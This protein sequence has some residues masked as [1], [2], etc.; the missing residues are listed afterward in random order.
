MPSSDRNISGVFPAALVGEE[1]IRDF[2]REH[3]KPLKDEEEALAKPWRSGFRAQLPFFSLLDDRQQAH[4]RGIFSHMLPSPEVEVEDFDREERILL[5]VLSETYIA[6][7]RVFAELMSEHD[8]Q[9]L[10]VVKRDMPG[11]VIA[12][13]LS[14]SVFVFD[15]PDARQIR[16]YRYQNIYGNR[17]V[18]PEGKC[19]LK[20]HM[21][22]AETIRSQEFRSSPLLM[23]AVHPETAQYRM[24]FRE[25][26]KVVSD[27]MSSRM[28]EVTFH[29]SSS[30]HA[31]TNVRPL[32]EV[33][34]EV[35]EDPDDVGDDIDTRSP[36][37]DPPLEPDTQ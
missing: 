21:R 29:A 36:G 25:E 16:R 33:Q 31:Y 14:A 37:T 12:L 7:A 1:Q 5:D 27:T 23:L 24:G 8:Y 10:P 2:L 15:V 17:H 35:D 13:T 30:F 4:L 28:K 20:G 6:Q 18:S 3:V 32:A 19:R 22:L 26:S 34:S 9:V 11:R